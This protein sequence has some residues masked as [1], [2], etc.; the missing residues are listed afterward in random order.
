MRTSE[1]SV[2]SLNTR[3]RDA[4]EILLTVDQPMLIVV[5]DEGVLAGAVPEASIIRALLTHG[6][7]SA[8]IESIVSRHIESVSRDAQLSSVL[9]VFRSTCH[10]VMPVLDEDHLVVGLL[11]R[12]DVVRTL[13]SDEP[14]KSPTEADSATAS[15]NAGS[16][17][18]PHFL[19]D[20]PQ[21]ASTD[22]RSG[23]AELQDDQ[24]DSDEL[25]A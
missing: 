20:R 23:N 25:N 10:T 15:D 11:H 19:H 22:E 24:S 8:T 14:G 3:L 1:A 4:A 5:D 7:E 9:H 16:L 12:R 13:L 21:A 18:G 6:C 2:I 17:S